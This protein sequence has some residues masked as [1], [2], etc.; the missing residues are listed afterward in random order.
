MAIR[1]GTSGFIY[2]HWRR[3]FYPPSARGSE[4]ELYARAFD[5]VELNVTFYRMPPSSTFRSWAARVPEGFLFAVK[6]S[7]YLTHVRRLKEPAS[8][9]ELLVE[10]A[11][12]LG[13]HLGP[14]LIQLPPDLK[15]DLAALEATL[16]AFPAGIRLAVEPR[17]SSWF[18]DDIRRALA[19]RN[20]ALCVADRRGPITPLWRTA[21]WTY[22][23]F[24]A[25]RAAPRS[26]YDPAELD[27][28]PSGSKAGGAATRRASSTS[29][30]TA[31]P[32]PCATRACSRAPWIGAASGWR[33][34][35]SCLTTCSSTRASSRPTPRAAP[36]APRPAPGDRPGPLPDARLRRCTNDRAATDAADSGRREPPGQ[37]GRDRHAGSLLVIGERGARVHLETDRLAIG[38][39]TQVD[40]TEL[41]PE[42]GCQA[43][44]TLAKVGVDRVW[45][46]ERVGS[47]G[48]ARISV[49]GGPV[50]HPRRE[51]LVAHGMDPEVDPVDP[52]LELDGAPADAVQAGDVEIGQHVDDRSDPAHRLVDQAP[53]P[54]PELDD[55]LGIAGDERLR[56]RKAGGRDQLELI[57]LGR[58]ARLGDARD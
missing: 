25:G 48:C 15:L 42:R 24:H 22:L 34:S 7:R 47:T 51:D 50:G 36:R 8:S 35:R 29:T 17:H 31:M 49:V 5:T 6:A 1:I 14:I 11:S 30:T 55:R 52:G 9:V 19:E 53:V 28:G 10:R 40:A 4:L 46:D 38:R 57:G 37:G 32:A 13:S 16:D 3:R 56:Y 45:L 20:V 27:S 54:R 26:C 44:A 39:D 21:D 41:E 58:V 23:R 18:V 12:E 2:E 33:A 43:D